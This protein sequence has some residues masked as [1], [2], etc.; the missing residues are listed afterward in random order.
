MLRHDGGR[1]HVHSLG[2]APNLF[3]VECGHDTERHPSGHDLI[4]LKHGVHEALKFG[5]QF[6]V[7]PLFVDV[8]DVR[9]NVVEEQRTHVLVRNPEE[10]KEE[11]QK[12]RWVQEIAI[13]E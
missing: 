12:I 11:W 13:T 5:V 6:V 8:L 7:G 2:I 10:T 9:N 3:P 4:I 1:H